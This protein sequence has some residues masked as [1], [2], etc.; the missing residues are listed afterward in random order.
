MLFFYHIFCSGNNEGFCFYFGKF[1]RLHIRIVYHQTECFGIQSCGITFS[2][3][4]LCNLITY[5]NGNLRGAFY[6]LRIQIGAIQNQSI[7][8]IRKLNSKNHSDISAIRK[9]KQMCFFYL[10]F[11]HE[12]KQVISKLAYSKG[13]IASRCFAVTSCVQCI[14]MIQLRERVDLS[15]KV[16]AILSVSM[17]Q[18]KRFPGSFFYEIVID[19][20]SF[21][22]VQT[23]IPIHSDL[24]FYDYIISA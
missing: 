17:K 13:L 15:L 7:D 14:Y 5:F 18:N 24:S 10:V 9:P 3:K 12:T 20:Y 11:I 6:P 1:F 22:F 23:N 4:F 16:A 8:S 19:V 21:H 2:C